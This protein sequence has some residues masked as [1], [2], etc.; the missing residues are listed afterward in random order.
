MHTRDS[1]SLGSECAQTAFD[2][3]SNSAHHSADTR[4]FSQR[5]G[6]CNDGLPILGLTQADF[7][8]LAKSAAGRGTRLS[9][10]SRIESVVSLLARSARS[11]CDRIVGSLRRPS[12]PN[13]D[14]S[15]PPQKR[16]HF[17]HGA[18]TTRRSRPGA[19]RLPGRTQKAPNPRNGQQRRAGRAGLGRRWAVSGPTPPR[20]RHPGPPGRQNHVSWR[21]WR[22][23]RP[24]GP[25]GPENAQAPQNAQDPRNLV[26]CQPPPSGAASGVILGTRNLRM[27]LP[28][29]DLQGLA[30][31]P[32]PQ[33]SRN[34]ARC[35]R[36]V[37]CRK[38]VE[39]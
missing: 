22:S 29:L 39:N 26:G 10:V 14:A 13:N 18:P 5:R 21:T 8:P 17:A 37:P 31:I 35:P 9:F 12:A 3:F 20:R 23:L 11:S 33:N 34:N 6:S 28:W 19:A 38:A 15:P 2:R 1:R 7:V 36:A 16:P 4:T 25:T 24:G 30:P 32:P 27:W